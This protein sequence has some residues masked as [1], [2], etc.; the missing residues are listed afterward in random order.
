MNSKL[1]FALLSLA[2]AGFANADSLDQRAAAQLARETAAKA[3][4]A[5]QAGG[6]PAAAAPA[7]VKEVQMPERPDMVDLI[8]VKGFAGKLEAV[9]AV[10]GRRATATMRTPLLHHGWTMTNIGPECAEVRKAGPKPETRN[11]CFVMPG[12][13]GPAQAAP[14]A[15]AGAPLPPGMPLGR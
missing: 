13:P 10:N 12:P 7:R 3:A 8:S 15:S 9:I 4:A 6:P 5:A 1:L 2:L 14:M 11:V